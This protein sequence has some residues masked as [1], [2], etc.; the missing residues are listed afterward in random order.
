M[1]HEK[2][3]IITR[4]DFLG[5][6]EAEVAQREAQYCRHRRGR[7]TRRFQFRGSFRMVD[8]SCLDGCDC[9]KTQC[10]IVLGQHKQTIYEQ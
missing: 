10:G 6:A 7:Q 8:R 4:R 5:G 1:S 2:K 3:S 9:L